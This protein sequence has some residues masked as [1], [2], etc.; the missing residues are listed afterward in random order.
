MF[1]TRRR[2]ALPTEVICVDFIIKVVE[3]FKLLGVT[4]DDKLN[5]AR[6]VSNTCIIINHKLNSIEKLFY[7]CTTVKVQF[8]KSFIL[9]YFGYCLSLSIY[10]SKSI[11]Q[12]LCNS[13]NI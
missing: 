12:K 1:V 11:L 6:H 9:P 4:I 2:I 7:L 3:K 5:F 13:Y 10:Y 8:F